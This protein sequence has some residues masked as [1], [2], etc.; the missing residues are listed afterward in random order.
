MTSVGLGEL[1]SFPVDVSYA[2][3]CDAFSRSGVAAM[4]EL[5]GHGRGV[6][7]PV[8]VGH[9]RT[10]DGLAG[11]LGVAARDLAAAFW[12]GPLTLLCTAQRTLDWDLGGDG[13]LAVRMPLHPIALQL[14]DRTGPMAVTGANPPGVS[15]LPRSSAEVRRAFAEGVH[16]Y[17][18]GGHLS[19]TGPWGSGVSSVVDV[20]GEH[21]HLLR[22]GALDAAALREVVPD[23]VDDTDPLDDTEG[24]AE[25][26]G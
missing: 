19:G 26:A 17:L 5:K 3:G 2:L 13:T 11:S 14:L 20:T 15:A 4:R 8:M 18:D 23:L 1:V 6:P 25:P 12:P 10:L 22:A 9:V 16:V 7:P 21:P 24:T